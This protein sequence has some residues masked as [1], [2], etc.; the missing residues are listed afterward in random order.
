MGYFVTLPVF[1]DFSILDVG[2][3]DTSLHKWDTLLHDP[4]AKPVLVL[5]SGISLIIF[6]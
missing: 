6:S 3:W 2:R 1:N 5:V 4:S